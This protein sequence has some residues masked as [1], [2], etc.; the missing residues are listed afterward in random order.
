MY[1]P[2]ETKVHYW[3]FETIRWNK[4]PKGSWEYRLY[5]KPN[6][7]ILI[8]SFWI[9]EFLKKRLKFWNEIGL[10]WSILLKNFL[11]LEGTTFSNSELYSL[12]SPVSSPI[13][14]ACLPFQGEHVYLSN[15]QGTL[16]SLLPGTNLHIYLRQ[17]IALSVFFLKEGD[18]FQ[19]LQ[20]GQHKAN[21]NPPVVARCKLHKH[22]YF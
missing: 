12:F 20:C 13:S 15:F 17:Y 16:T 7:L 14:D 9:V 18:L 1:R 19:N 5:K 10:G 8:R 2:N 4:I 3:S 11:D 22:F 21:S 6:F